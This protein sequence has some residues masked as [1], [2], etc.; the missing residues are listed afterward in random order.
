M[1]REYFKNNLCPH[2]LCGELLL[3]D[4]VRINVYRIKIK[5]FV[6]KIPISMEAHSGSNYSNNLDIKIYEKGGWF[7]SRDDYFK[8]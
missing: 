6:D 2:C 4:L 1:T 8:I 3:L 5:V 7:E